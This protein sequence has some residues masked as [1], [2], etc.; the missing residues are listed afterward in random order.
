MIP[1]EGLHKAMSC[2]ITDGTCEIDETELLRFLQMLDM[3]SGTYEVSSLSPGL[4][5]HGKCRSPLDPDLLVILI[6]NSEGSI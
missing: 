1:L 4:T 2:G 5:G 6:K 3:S